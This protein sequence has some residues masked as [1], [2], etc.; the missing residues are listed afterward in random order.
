VV[1]TLSEA[2]PGSRRRDAVREQ[3]RL[4]GEALAEERAGRLVRAA[5]RYRSAIGINVANPTPYLFLGYVLQQQGYADCATQAW[6]LAADLDARLVNAWR[7]PAVGGDVRERSRAADEAIRTHFTALHDKVMASFESEHPG[8]DIARIRNAIWCQTPLDKFSYNTPGQRPHVF[9]VPEL[10]PIDVY[11]SGALDW[12]AQLESAAHI[13]REEFL[14]ASDSAA[15]AARP[16]LS[17][18]SDAL[19]QEWEPIAQSLNW[20]AFH[21]YRQG[22]ANDALLRLFPR[23]LA[24]LEQLPLLRTYAAPSEILFSVLQGNKHIPP[25]YGLSNTDLVVHLPVITTDESAIRVNGKDYPWQ[26]GKVLAF[27][28]SFLHES[29]NHSGDARVNLLFEVWHPELTLHERAAISAGFEARDS[30][31]R[32]RS[33]EAKP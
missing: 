32:D 3:N 4:C 19:G 12:H 20:G 31:N 7:N 29:W 26:F 25:H 24:V 2:D 33:I 11:E 1:T 16:Y 23:T 18:T 6:S 21:L 27:D 8:C 30:W 5:D 17:Q 10:A 13:I 28:D 22:Q 9:Y 14:A 15:D